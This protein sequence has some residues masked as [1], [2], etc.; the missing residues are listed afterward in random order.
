MNLIAGTLPKGF[1]ICGSIFLRSAAVGQAIIAPTG[2][3]LVGLNPNQM[4]TVVVHTM[5]VGHRIASDGA[6]Q[7]EH[8]RRRNAHQQPLKCV[9]EDLEQCTFLWPRVSMNS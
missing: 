4:A 5:T 3:V 8:Q 1:Q 2:A 6:R 7:N 9:D